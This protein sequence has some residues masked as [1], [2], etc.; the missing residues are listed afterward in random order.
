MPKIITLLTIF[1]TT[2]SRKSLRRIAIIIT[3]T[4]WSSGRVTMLGLSR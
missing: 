3:A 4:L 1:K 2:F